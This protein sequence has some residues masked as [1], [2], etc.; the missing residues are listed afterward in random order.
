MPV[1]TLFVVLTL[2]GS[3]AP[4]PFEG[5]WIAEYRGATYVRLTLQTNGGV[6]TGSLSLGDVEFGKDGTVVK[7]ADA[8]KAMSKI[9]DVRREG[10]VLSFSR[11]E[12][13]DT[14]RFQL[15]IAGDALTLKFLPSEEDLQELADAGI[16]APKPF[17]LIRSK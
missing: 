15:T 5:T 2:A 12:S 13:E 8:P 9:F 16:P 17:R 14:D 3:Q 4:A 6:T 7:A 11:K 1:L 10:N